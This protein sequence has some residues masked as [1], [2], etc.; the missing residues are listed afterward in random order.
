MHDKRD[1]LGVVAG[2]DGN[3]YAIGGFGGVGILYF[4][5]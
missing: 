1:E 2:F 4:K 3:I 5:I